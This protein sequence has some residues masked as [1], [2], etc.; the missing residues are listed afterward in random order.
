VP[1]FEALLA[2]FSASFDTLSEAIALKKPEKT[3]V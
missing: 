2:S 1:I 3:N